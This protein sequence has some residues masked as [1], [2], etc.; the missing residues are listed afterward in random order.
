MSE[1]VGYTFFYN[2]EV[3]LITWLQSHLGPVGISIASF[4]TMCGEELILTAVV[5]FIYWCY[6]KEMGRTVGLNLVTATVWNPLIKNIFYRRRPYF[7]HKGIEGLRP[8]DADAPLLDIR[9]QGYSF[10]SGHSTNSVA[11]YFSIYLNKRTQALHILAV[12]MMLLIGFSRVCLGVHYPTDVICGWALGFLT[13]L[14]VSFLQKKI[15]NRAV[16]YAI[17]IL[18]GIP[19]WFY[20]TTTDFYTSYGLLVGMCGGFLLEEKVIHFEPAET[21]LQKIL[22]LVIGL[23]LFL[24]LVNLLKL[25]FSEEFLESGSFAARLART[26]RYAVSGFITIGPYSM[27]FRPVRRLMTKNKTER[28]A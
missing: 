22:R 14:V 25:P 13:I 27:L 5:G 17:L 9:H 18:T 2:W 4:F 23:V 16:L 20:C 24:A 10:P 26:A 8:V 28:N 21:V 6:N 19:G 11:A 7:D 12:G 3:E 1:F 15:A